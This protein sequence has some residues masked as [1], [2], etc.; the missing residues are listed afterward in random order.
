MILI[1]SSS[2]SLKSWLAASEI[3]TVWSFIYL[4]T[5]GVLL[6]LSGAREERADDRVGCP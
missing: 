6:S 3:F 2:M 4:F 1:I 5:M